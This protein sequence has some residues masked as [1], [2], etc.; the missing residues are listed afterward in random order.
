MTYPL[1]IVGENKRGIFM[2]TVLSPPPPEK[3][4]S[5]LDIF[6]RMKVSEKEARL[7]S[8]FSSHIC[9]CTC[10]NDKQSVFFLWGSESF[11]RRKEYKFC[12]SGVEVVFISF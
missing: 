11:Q 5:A 2:T 8:F 6:F 3:S 4:Q 9:P 12:L 7:Y 1:A 10:L